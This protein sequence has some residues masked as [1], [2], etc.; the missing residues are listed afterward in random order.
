MRT[1]R[2]NSWKNPP[3]CLLEIFEIQPKNQH[4]TTVIND[5]QLKSIIDSSYKSLKIINLSNCIQL[6]KLDIISNCL[7]ITKLT[8]SQNHYLSSGD[9]NK[10]CKSCENL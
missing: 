10:I 1:T 2:Q 6:M 4:L 5:S 9:L 3:G 7:Q 8:I